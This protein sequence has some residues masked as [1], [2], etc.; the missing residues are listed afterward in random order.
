[1]WPCANSAAAFVRGVEFFGKGREPGRDGQQASHG[2]GFTGKGGWLSA[3]AV[4]AFGIGP[5]TKTPSWAV[6]PRRRKGKTAECS[7]ISL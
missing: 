4:S 7:L 2:M 5:S 6:T 1:M 3:V